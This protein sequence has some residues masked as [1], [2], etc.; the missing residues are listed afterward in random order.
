MD[1]TTDIEHKRLVNRLKVRR[2]KK[3]LKATKEGLDPD[4]Y[5]TDEDYIDGLPEISAASP[6]TEED[7]G[8]TPGSMSLGLGIIII[9]VI[10]LV[11]FYRASKAQETPEITEEKNQDT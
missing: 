5:I 8:V 4:F 11:I 10:G 1:T 6:D 2:Y 9:V 3:R 7:E